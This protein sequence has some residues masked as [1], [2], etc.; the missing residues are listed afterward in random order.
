MSRVVIPW[1][2][3]GD[4]LNPIDQN[5]FQTNVITLS[6]DLT[7][8]NIREEGISYQNIDWTNPP[9]TAYYDTISKVGS[10]TINSETYSVVSDGI[11]DC[12][13]TGIS[14]TI[15]HGTVL[16]LTSRVL[17]AKT[18]ISNVSDDYLLFKHRLT[19]ANAGNV[20][21]SPEYV[22]SGLAC[23]TTNNST[24]VNDIERQACLMNR[25]YIYPTSLS[26]TLQTVKLM[27]KVSDNANTFHLD[28]F[29]LTLEVITR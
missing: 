8:Q 16:R 15:N 20:D 23:N 4:T 3:V 27:T 1:I 13:L 12:S 5:T 10:M 7:S 21:L 29:S 22:Y 18:S 19:Y 17:L 11:T 24:E 26:D 6:G 14:H 28:R 9:T 25:M 2:Q